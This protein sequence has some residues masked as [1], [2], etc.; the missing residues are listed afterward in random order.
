MMH[1]YLFVVIFNFMFRYKMGLIN[2]LET[3]NI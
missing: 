1:F 3:A 2:L